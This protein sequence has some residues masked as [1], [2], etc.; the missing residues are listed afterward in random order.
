MSLVSC[1]AY[2]VSNYATWVGCEEQELTALAESARNNTQG[3]T[4]RVHQLEPELLQV[5]KELEAQEANFREERMKAIKREYLLAF[6]P[7][8]LIPNS[9]SSAS[10]VAET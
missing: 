6:S 3:P 7:N 8:A 1:I 9:A 4:A 5:K 10:I 2:F